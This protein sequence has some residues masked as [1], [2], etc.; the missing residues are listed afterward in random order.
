MH[1]TVFGTLPLVYKLV[2]MQIDFSEKSCAEFKYM[3]KRN[4]VGTFCV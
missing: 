2:S 1:K 4:N 3:E